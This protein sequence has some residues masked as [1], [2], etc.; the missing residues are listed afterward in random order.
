M[1]EHR[2][3][4]SVEEELELERKRGRQF[5]AGHY[6]PRHRSRSRSRQARRA[7]SSSRGRGRGASR[8]PVRRGGRRT[9]SEGIKARAKAVMEDFGWLV[10]AL[11]E[12]EGWLACESKERREEKEQAAAA[13]RRHQAETAQLRDQLAT[14]ERRGSEYKTQNDQHKAE[15]KELRDELT[16]AERRWNRY[17]AEKAKH[18]AQVAQERQRKEQEKQQVQ[19]QR[20]AEQER[21]KAAQEKKDEERATE[22]SKFKEENGVLRARVEAQQ[23]QLDSQAGVIETLSKELSELRLAA[24][25]RVPPTPTEE[26]AGRVADLETRVKELE[27][28]KDELNQQFARLAGDLHLARSHL[29]EAKSVL[30]SAHLATP[31]V[32][33]RS[34]MA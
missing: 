3:R 16:K 23:Q 4:R 27:G 25:A 28:D 34:H 15:A 7:K 13:T 8:S 22:L 10:D 1:Q 18:K 6:T 19:A 31:R 21:R 29:N 12:C 30:V 24:D 20:A 5:T 2:L 26:A 32:S 17:M 9:R 14:A 11:E 33:S